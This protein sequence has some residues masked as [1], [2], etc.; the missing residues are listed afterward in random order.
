MIYIVFYNNLFEWLA[1]QQ[2]SSLWP[3]IDRSVHLMHEQKRLLLG[4]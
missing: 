3:L 2:A 4:K 1:Y